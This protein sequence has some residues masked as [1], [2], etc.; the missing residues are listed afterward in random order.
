MSGTTSVFPHQMDTQG[1]LYNF[2]NDLDGERKITP[3]GNVSDL[4]QFKVRISPNI[5][6]AQRVFPTFLLHAL[7]HVLG[8]RSARSPE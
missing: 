3:V 2:Y 5:H 6:L 4:Q 7:S 1:N 8:D